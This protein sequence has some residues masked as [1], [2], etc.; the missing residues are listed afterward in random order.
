MQALPSS[1]RNV[2]VLAFDAD[3]TL[4][5]N[6]TLY[7]KAEARWAEVL[8]DYGTLEELSAALYSVESANMPL[9]GYGTRAFF[10]SL[11]ETSLKVSGNALKGE[12]TGAILD[13]ARDLLHNPATPLPGVPETLESIRESKRYIMVLLTKGD[14]LDQELKIERSGLGKFFDYVDIVSNKSRKEYLDICAK[15]GICPAEFLMVGNSF[16]SDIAPVLEIGG[17]GIHVPFH[18]TWEHERMEEFPHPN[19]AKVRSFSE[20]APLLLGDSAA[21]V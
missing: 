3:D 18:V 5:E 21:G 4:W 1:F 16:K 17:S 12:Q 13:I 9:Y 14:L 2:R 8:K 19:L 10:M 11:V 7:R 6:E 20:I 15:Y